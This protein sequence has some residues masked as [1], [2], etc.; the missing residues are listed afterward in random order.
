MARQIVT[1]GLLTLVE[2]AL[3]HNECSSEKPL[4]VE[5]Y[6]VQD[7]VVVQNNFQPKNKQ[8]L[9]STGIGLKNLKSRYA[10]LTSQ[11]VQVIED[12]QIFEVKIPFV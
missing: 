4:K 3:K 12:D 9:D 5:V 10:L 7:G 8:F 6:A 11:K 2:N 1:Q